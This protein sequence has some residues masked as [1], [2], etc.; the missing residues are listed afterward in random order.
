[1][2][3]IDNKEGAAPLVHLATI[4]D[5]HRING[6]YFN[7]MKADSRTS[8]QARNP[9]LAQRLWAHTETMLSLSSNQ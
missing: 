9:E 7:K 6:Q 5:P 1:M 4:A 2:L 8:K 3:M